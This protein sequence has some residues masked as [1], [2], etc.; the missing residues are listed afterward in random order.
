MTFPQIVSHNQ[1]QLPKLVGVASQQEV[2]E[3]TSTT[4]VS[5]LRVCFDF[6]QRL[7]DIPKIKTLRALVGG[8]PSVEHIETQ[9]IADRL[10]CLAGTLQS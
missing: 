1:T 5:S 2:F 4:L 6:P 3:R 10:L 8:D 7:L 9:E